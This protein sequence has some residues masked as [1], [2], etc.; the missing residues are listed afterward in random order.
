M[1]TCPQKMCFRVKDIKGHETMS[2]DALAKKLTNVCTYSREA[3]RIAIKVFLAAEKKL[4]KSLKAGM[5]QA[6]E[7]KVVQKDFSEFAPKDKSFV[8][9]AIKGKKTLN[10]TIDQEVAYL[11]KKGWVGSRDELR[12]MVKDRRARR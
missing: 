11:R 8:N 3:R 5:K 7:G 6:N 4:H 2:V 12:K 9:H 10:L 1:K